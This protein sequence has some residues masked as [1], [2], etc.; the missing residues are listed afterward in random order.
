MS[1]PSTPAPSAGLDPATA[2]EAMLA[3]HDQEAV[4]GGDLASGDLLGDL[5]DVAD[6]QVGFAGDEEGDVR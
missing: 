6:Q 5:G 3:R 4:Q 1:D 2:G